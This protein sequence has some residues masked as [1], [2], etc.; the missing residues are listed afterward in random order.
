MDLHSVVPTAAATLSWE[1]PPITITS[2]VLGVSFPLVPSFWGH[3]AYVTLR[4]TPGVTHVIKG[5]IP[6]GFEGPNLEVREE[7]VL[8]PGC[9]GSWSETLQFFHSTNRRVQCDGFQLTLLRTATTL[10]WPCSLCLH[11]HCPA[12]P[13]PFRALPENSP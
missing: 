11:S 6:R 13:I 9:H 4:L 10:T 7:V 5:G 3:Y 1:P 12:A 8:A 2:Q